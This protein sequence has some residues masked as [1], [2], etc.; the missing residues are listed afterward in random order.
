MTAEQCA[1]IY[2]RSLYMSHRRS[3][4]IFLSFFDI[5][6][7]DLSQRK[8]HCVSLICFALLYL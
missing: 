7:S 1:E 3:L 2:L 4:N 5:I 6:P 8:I